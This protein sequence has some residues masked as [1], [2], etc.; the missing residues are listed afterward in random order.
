MPGITQPHF[1]SQ[2]LSNRRHSRKLREFELEEDGDNL[3]PRFWMSFSLLYAPLGDNFLMPI[4]KPFFSIYAVMAF[5]LLCGCALKVQLPA[6]VSSISS[7][8]EA[9][10]QIVI[11]GFEELNDRAQQKLF[12]IG[13]EGSDNIY[14]SVKSDE[15][16]GGWRIAG[17]AT[18]EVSKCTIQVSSFVVQRDTIRKGLLKGVLWH[19][20]GHC[21]GFDDES[22]YGEVMYSG[23]ELFASYSA[24]ASSRFLTRMLVNAGL[25]VPTP[26][27][28]R[29]QVAWLGTSV[30]TGERLDLSARAG[31]K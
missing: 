31:E 1:F 12:V 18:M 20:I 4:R 11:A 8:S 21:V 2:N 15:N 25:P 13:G 17:T 29:G 28:P 26:G 3:C 27:V 5:F 9:Q 19:E 6:H 24:A 7:F 30:P 23:P 16:A 14:V 10:R 22:A